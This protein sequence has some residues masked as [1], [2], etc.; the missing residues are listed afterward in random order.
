MTVLVMLIA[1]GILGVAAAFSFLRDVRMV[2]IVEMASLA[3]FAASPLILGKSMSP[4]VLER[5]AGK[6]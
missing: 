4:W 3:D 2:S 5:L 6:L 1:T